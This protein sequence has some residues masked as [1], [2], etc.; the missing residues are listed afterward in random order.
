MTTFP[1]PLG[2]QSEFFLPLNDIDGEERQLVKSFGEGVYK[3]EPV[4]SNYH[5]RLRMCLATGLALL[6]ASD[7]RVWM[8][9]MPMKAIDLLTEW[10][11]TLGLSVAPF[12]WT[13]EDRW[14][15]LRT[16]CL[17]EYK[18]A[19]AKTIAIAITTLIYRHL[20]GWSYETILALFQQYA[21]TNYIVSETDTELQTPPIMPPSEL[22][23]YEV[24]VIVPLSAYEDVTLWRELCAL[25]DRM[26]PANVRIALNVTSC[27]RIG[28]GKRPNFRWGVS[29]WDRDCW[30][31]GLDPSP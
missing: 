22:N 8:N 26:S 15:R 28:G 29:V 10:E 4:D 16:R 31:T 7:F 21:Y 11:E 19:D 30:G 5:W 1:V 6:D 12:N 23:R 14:E 9:S 18:G 25:R 17:Q 20:Y 2:G 3:E 27:D 13:I 24:A